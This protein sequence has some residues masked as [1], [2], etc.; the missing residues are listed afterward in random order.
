MIKLTRT[1]RHQGPLLFHQSSHI[2]D[3]T[4]V[5]RDIFLRLRKFHPQPLHLALSG[6]GRSGVLQ[7][8]FAGS[9]HLSKL[10]L[11]RRDLLFH[12]S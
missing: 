4:L 9:S 5:S 12:S 3:F 1:R 10:M 6:S 11:G 2:S 8:L 7:T